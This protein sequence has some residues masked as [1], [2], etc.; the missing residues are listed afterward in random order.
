MD[1]SVILPVNENKNSFEDY[2][3]KSIQSIVKNYTL[4]VVRIKNLNRS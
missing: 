4:Y 3:N 1:V 2:F